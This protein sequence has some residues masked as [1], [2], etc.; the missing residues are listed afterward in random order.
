QLLEELSGADIMAKL[1]TVEGREPLG[2]QFAGE[3]LIFVPGPMLRDSQGRQ[4]TDGVIG[5]MDK[6]KNP[7]KIVTVVESKAGALAAEGL[8]Y[9]ETEIKAV[10]SVYYHQYNKVRKT[11]PKAAPEL[12]ATPAAAWVR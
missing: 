9:G 11:T 4:L 8:R 12:G 7:F 6:E 3:E 2:G 5:F 10:R 1:K